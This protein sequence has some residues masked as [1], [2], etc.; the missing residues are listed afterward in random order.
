MRVKVKFLSPMTKNGKRREIGE[1]LE[2]DSIQAML[3]AKKGNV[4]IPGYT[5][6]TIEQTIFVDTL[7][8]IED[9]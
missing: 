2:I 5:I 7:I 4:E 1:T 6:K 9:K 8:P 3:L